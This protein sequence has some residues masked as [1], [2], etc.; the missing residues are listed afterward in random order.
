[1]KL[2]PQWRR[3]RRRSSS[4]EAKAA[5][6]SAKRRWAFYC[7]ESARMWQLQFMPAAESGLLM[8]LPALSPLAEQFRRVA[9][10]GQ[11][12]CREASRQIRV[13]SR[14]DSL[15]ENGPLAQSHGTRFPILQGPMTRV[16]DTP[17]FALAV[18]KGG[19]LPFLALA[20][21]RGPQ[22]QKLLEQTKEQLGARTWGVRSL[23][24]VPK[25]LRDEQLAGVMKYKPPYA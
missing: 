7:S 11:A 18:A 6:E 3:M 12:I 22:V 20:L 5:E 9:G 4:K 8:R 1:M 10:I 23:G 14:L 2:W 19:A 16:S 13:A 17:E 21:M 24:F 25:E 15:G